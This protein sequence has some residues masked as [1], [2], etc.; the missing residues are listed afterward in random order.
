MNHFVFHDSLQRLEPILACDSTDNCLSV[1][2]K[3]SVKRCR[4]NGNFEI[5]LRFSSYL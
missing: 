2:A 1:V 4:G 5:D 3:R